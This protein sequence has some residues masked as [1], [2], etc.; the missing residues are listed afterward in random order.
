MQE[1]E[2]IVQAKAAANR[3]KSSNVADPS[4]LSIYRLDDYDKEESKGSA[5]G[6]FSNIKSV[7]SEIYKHARYSPYSEQRGL[8]YY[9]DNHEDPYITLKVFL[10]LA[11]SL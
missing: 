1:A 9:Q 10:L 3:I 2:A 11:F 6:A 7:L 4:D 5:M 8:Q